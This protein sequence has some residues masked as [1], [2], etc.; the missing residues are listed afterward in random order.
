MNKSGSNFWRAAYGSTVRIQH[1]LSLHSYIDGQ[2]MSCILQFPTKMCASVGTSVGLITGN[3]FSVSRVMHIQNLA[4]CYKITLQ[5]VMPWK[6][7]LTMNVSIYLLLSSPALASINILIFWLVWKLN[8]ALCYF[9]LHFLIIQEVHPLS[10]IFL[11]FS[12]SFII[13]L[14]FILLPC[15]LH[16]N[17]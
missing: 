10:L 1:H 11:A 17:S 2:S 5:E 8:L 4:K 7:S 3:I 9:D 14:F 15:R 12:L 16:L 6:S 13:Y